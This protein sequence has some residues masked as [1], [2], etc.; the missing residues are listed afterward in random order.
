MDWIPRSLRQKQKKIDQ[1]MT[2]LETELCRSAT[3]EEIAKEL[4]ITE[5]ELT[6]WQ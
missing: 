5:E 3:D 6:N 1:A 4:D 2:K